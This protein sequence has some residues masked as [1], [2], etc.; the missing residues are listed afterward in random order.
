MTV[1]SDDPF[2]SE[3]VVSLSLTVTQSEYELFLPAVHYDD[4]TAA[5]PVGL[6]PLAGMFLLPALVFG[7]RKKQR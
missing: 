1:T 2:N 3:L 5:Q 4:G 7:W 6:A